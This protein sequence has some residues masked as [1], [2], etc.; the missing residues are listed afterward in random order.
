MSLVIE[1]K[2]A[3]VTFDGGVLGAEERLQPRS[4]SSRG[5]LARVVAWLEAQSLFVALLAVV[6]GLSLEQLPRDLNQDG[7]LALVGGRYVAQHGIPEHDILNV[8]SHGASWIDEQWLSQLALYGVNQ[9]GGLALYGLLSV[10]LTVCGL[11]ATIVAARQL[12]GTERNIVLVLPAAAFLYFAGSFQIRTQSLTYPLFVGTLWLLAAEVRNPG[13]RRIYLVFP[14]LILW[15]NLHGSVTMGAGLVMLCGITLLAQDLRTARAEGNWGRG[16]RARPIAL[17]LGAP[18]CLFATPYG[19]AVVGYYHTMLL[20]PIW[21]GMVTEFQPVTAIVTLAVPFFALALA[22]GWVLG[23]SGARTPLFDRLT[24]LI[25]AAGAVWA[26]RNVAWFGLAAAM[27]LPAAL[28]GISKPRP[29]SRRRPRLNLAIASLAIAFLVAS[30]LSVLAQPA[31]WFERAYDLSAVRKVADI[32]RRHPDAL[33]YSDLRFSDW[34]LWHDPALAGHL[35]YD[36]RVQLLT[37]RQLRALAEVTQ[38]HRRGQTDILAP[39]S[40]LVLDPNNEPTTQLLLY[41]PGTRL[42]FHSSRTV[43][44]TRQ[45]TPAPPRALGSQPIILR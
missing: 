34:L 42:V 45:A 16:L 26:V 20:N 3:A 10:V 32:V 37:A 28:T 6:A 36:T 14:L 38:I 40:V 25:L 2:G 11:G 8:L 22:T 44:A 30:G 12:G 27:L 39:Y 41:R 5:G 18:M 33:I 43:V 9:L 23:R 21:S 35:A 7:W 1:L 31:S 15:G 17:V 19:V 13:R 4:P 24:L 29:M